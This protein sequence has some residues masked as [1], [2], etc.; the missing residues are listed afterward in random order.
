[1]LAAVTV[2]TICYVS[3]ATAYLAVLDG[4]VVMSSQAIA[5]DFGMQMSSGSGLAAMLAFGVVISAAGS[6]NGSIMTGGRA[7]F[8]VARLGFAPNILSKLN[9]MGAPYTSLL[10]QGAWGM[11]LLLLPGSSFG[12]LLNYFGPTSWLFYAFTSSGVIVLR[13]KEPNLP[14]PFRIPFYPL[15]PLLTFVSSVCI[16]YSS[17]ATEPLYCGLALCFVFLSYPVWEVKRHIY[18]DRAKSEEGIARGSISDTNNVGGFEF[19][20]VAQREL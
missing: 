3:L 13:H 20:A 4:Q 15:P 1:M 16:V 5:I 19:A 14:R 8:A 6:C 18:P 17:L 12:S 7:F 11:V 10:A 9:S 2:V